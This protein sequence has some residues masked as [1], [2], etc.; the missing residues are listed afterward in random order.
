MDHSSY[1]RSLDILGETSHG[2]VAGCKPVASAK[3]G[4]IPTS[5][6]PRV[7]SEMVITSAF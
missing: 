5:P 3:S 1:K 2:V 7:R 4:S 6:T